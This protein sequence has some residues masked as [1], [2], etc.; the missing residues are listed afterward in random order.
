MKIA[1]A[2]ITAERPMLSHSQ[3]R[4]ML[5]ELKKNNQLFIL[6]LP[7]ILYYLTFRYVPMIGHLLAFVDYRY[8]TG[9][10]RSPFIGLKNFEYLFTS[11]KLG[12]ITWNTFLFNSI[13]IVMDH[14]TMI[15]LAIIICEL[16]NKLFRK[17]SVSLIFLP[18]FVSY[19]LLGAFVYNLLNY[20]MGL[21]NTTLKS[22]GMQPVDVYSNPDPWLY[23]MPIFHW[24]KTVGYGMIIYIAAISSIPPELYESANIDGANVFQR[25]RYITMP[26][27]VPT[28]IILILLYIGRIFRG[29]FELFYQ[30]VGQNPLLFDRTD[31]I[32]TYVFR[33]ILINFDPG[34]AAAANLYQSILGFVTIMTANGL[35]RRYRSEYAL[36]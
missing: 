11:G 16:R 28:M 32:D 25:I 31:V 15:A 3:A 30:I 21:L 29:Q 33:S 35:I 14:T 2:K 23:L 8:D 1:E 19:V 20:E 10:F 18:F 9:F 6:L 36:Y 26:H 4:G 12:S 17:I 22:F 34:Q 27:I 24:W 5:F 13:F 7:V